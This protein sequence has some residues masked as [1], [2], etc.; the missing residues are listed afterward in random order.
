MFLQMACKVEETKYVGFF[1]PPTAKTDENMHRFPVGLRVRIP[2]GDSGM[3]E[4]G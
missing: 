3:K 2:G 1:L 4:G